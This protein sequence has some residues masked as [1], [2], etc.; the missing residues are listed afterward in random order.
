MSFMT[1]ETPRPDRSPFNDNFRGV[2]MS[3]EDRFVG[4]KALELFTTTLIRP[5]PWE[6]KAGKIV[7]VKRF[8]QHV[9][10]ESTPGIPYVPDLQERVII[11]QGLEKEVLSKELSQALAIFKAVEDFLP[12]YMGR[13]TGMFRNNL[14]ISASYNQWG[15]EEL[16]HS[17]A[18]GL[19]LERTGNKTAQ[20]LVEEHQANL[21]RT[22]ELPFPTQRQ[23]VLYAAFQERNTDLAYQALATQAEKEDAPITAKILRII[24]KDEAY[25]GGGYRAFARIYYDLD[26]EGTIQDAVHVAA[27]YRMPAQNLSPHPRSRAT[28]LIKVGALSRAMI[29]RDTILHTLRGFRFIPE[30]VIRETVR[31][32]EKK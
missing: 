12:D 22:W 6:I 13:A 16:Q 30:D 28:T 21:L 7:V 5:L 27:N 4:P 31:A 17:L 1:P 25:H 9:E 2:E 26:Q 8:D 11:T 32:F 3:E 23:M 10:L 29:E 24:S 20:Q 15:R 18:L 14:G 19:I